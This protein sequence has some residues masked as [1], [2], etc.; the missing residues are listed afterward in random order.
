V[1]V[2]YRSRIS[3][4]TAQVKY[5]KTRKW[6]ISLLLFLKKFPFGTVEINLIIGM[7]Y[8]YFLIKDPL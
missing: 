8:G 6:I 4:V 3:A 5:A 1:V 7:Y 2:I